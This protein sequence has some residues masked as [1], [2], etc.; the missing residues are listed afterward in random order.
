MAV[1]DGDDPLFLKDALQSILDNTIL[2]SEIILVVDGPINNNLSDVIQ[3]FL[4]LLPIKLVSL[5]RNEGLGKALNKGL[6]ACSHEWIARFDSD[7]IC[8]PDR[9]GKQLQFIEQNANIDAFSAPIIEFEKELTE[10]PF[11]IRDV[12]R[13]SSELAKYAKWRNPFNHMSV[14][15]RKSCVLKAGNYQDDPSFEDYSLWVRML[16]SGACLDNMEEAVVYAR[17]GTAIQNRRGGLEYVKREIKMLSKM[18]SWGFIS[19]PEFLLMAVLK[20][21]IRILPGKLR[22]AFYNI[23]TRKRANKRHS[24]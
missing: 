7:D 11:V 23:F 21:I 19:Y 24:K 1:Y 5:E 17:A 2:P 14:M 16:M 4:T 20:S 18:R 15:Y 9:F 10:G 8:M 12:P 3:N 22:L 6:L 13:G